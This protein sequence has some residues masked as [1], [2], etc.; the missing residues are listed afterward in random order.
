MIATAWQIPDAP[1]RSGVAGA[2]IVGLAGI[3]ATAWALRVPLHLSQDYLSKS[4]GVFALTMLLVLG[5]VQNGHPFPRFGA[6]NFITS[7]RAAIVALVAGLLAEPV[8]PEMATAA[9]VASTIATSLDGLDGW[10][11][12][13]TGMAS[14]FGARFDMEIDAL[15]ILA[16][17]ALTWQT[18]KAG[19][20]IVLAGLLRYLFMASAWI[21]PW[22][23]NALTPS[24]RRQA[25]CVVQIIGLSVVMLPIVQPPLSVWLSAALLATLVYSFFVDTLWLWR[26]GD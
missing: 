12:R 25:V 2:N 9:A 24:R 10:T 18:G 11:A 14:E 17:S 8:S 26:H 13:R 6:A 3:A 23:T 5:F 22:M 16:L 1:L 4:C 21:L 20:W 7:V 15:L 19:A